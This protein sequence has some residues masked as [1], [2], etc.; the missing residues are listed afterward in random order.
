MDDPK[1]L[2]VWLDTALSASTLVPDIRE[3]RPGITHD[4][5]YRLQ[6]EVMARRVAAGDRIVGYKAALTS[7]A[8]QA[9]VGIDEPLL[10]TLLGS[11][12]VTGSE[13]V[14]ISGW[15]FLRPTLEPEIAVVLGRD[16]QGPGVTRIDALRAIAGYLP[17]IELGD[18]RTSVEVGQTFIGAVVCNTFNGGIVLGQPYVAPA[19]IDLRREGMTMTHNGKPAGSGTG[20]EVL[21]DP[22]NSVIFIANKLAEYGHGLR[23][24]MILMTGSIVAS[25]PLAAGDD[26]DV[27]FTQLGA[28]RVRMA[29]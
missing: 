26:V 14:S 18:Y 25:I 13:P 21:G 29:A 27:E 3:L 5:A 9:Q 28:V 19:G 10:G 2:A 1:E 8:M 6:L 4:E 23:A 7:P 11:R 15:G 24:G 22:I 20:V 12:I 16:L 17:A